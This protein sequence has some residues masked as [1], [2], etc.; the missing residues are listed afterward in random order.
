MC[1]AVKISARIWEKRTEN[2]K[3]NPAS[4]PTCQLLKFILV[5][6]HELIFASIKW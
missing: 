3:S 2:L 4:F 5:T 1:G 6:F